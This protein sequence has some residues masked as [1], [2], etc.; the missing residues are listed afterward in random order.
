MQLEMEPNQVI[1]FLLNQ[2]CL[3]VCLHQTRTLSFS[4]ISFTFQFSNCFLV[5]KNI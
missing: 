5:S 2:I 3:F 4:I 1:H